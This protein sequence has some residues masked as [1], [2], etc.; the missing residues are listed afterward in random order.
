LDQWRVAAIVDDEDVNRKILRQCPE[1]VIQEFLAIVSGD[2]DR[3]FVL[4]IVPK[5]HP[6]PPEVN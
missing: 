5:N 2:E 1:S 6:Q 3:D 4:D